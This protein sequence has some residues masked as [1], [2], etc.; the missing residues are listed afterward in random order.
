[1]ADNTVKVTAVPFA[2]V[3]YLTLGGMCSLLSPAVVRQLSVNKLL[4]SI[5][6]KAPLSFELLALLLRDAIR[7]LSGE[8]GNLLAKIGKVPAL[9]Q[10]IQELCWK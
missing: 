8:F 9:S 1:V 3:V 4:T 2:L 6:D 7:N 10:L 5:I